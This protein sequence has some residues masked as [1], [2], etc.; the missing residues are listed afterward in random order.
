MPYEEGKKGRSKAH[1]PTKS[2]PDG[3]N[4]GFNS[5]A[6][7]ADSDSCFVVN[8]CHPSISRARAKAT[9]DVESRGD[10]DEQDSCHSENQTRVEV[11]LQREEVHTD[12]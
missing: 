3:Q 9:T 4:E 5:K 12:L 8:A 2:E 10:S 1:A 11:S 6:H 7:S